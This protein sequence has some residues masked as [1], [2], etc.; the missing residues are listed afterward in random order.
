MYV[1]KIK[2]K[3]FKKGVCPEGGSL[4]KERPTNNNITGAYSALMI[5]LFLYSDGAHPSSYSRQM[6]LLRWLCLFGLAESR[7][8]FSFTVKMVICMNADA[9]EK[10]HSGTTVGNNTFKS[11][12]MQPLFNL[13]ILLKRD[14]LRTTWGQRSTAV[15]TILVS[16]CFGPIWKHKKSWYHHFLCDFSF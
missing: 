10:W 13:C 9:I 5:T 14:V 11:I 6:Q 3:A 2:N 4:N 1:W 8:R 16:P 12:W 7:S 15:V